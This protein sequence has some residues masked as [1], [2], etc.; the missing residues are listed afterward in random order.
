MVFLIYFNE[1]EGYLERFI[2]MYV[3]FDK[4]FKKKNVFV[5]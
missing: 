2:W 1:K 3:F 4:L 5:K